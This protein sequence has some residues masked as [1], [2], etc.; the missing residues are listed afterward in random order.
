MPARPAP[1]STSCPAPAQRRT[2]AL[3]AVSSDGLPGARCPGARKGVAHLLR[4][5]DRR[6]LE[7]CLNPGTSGASCWLSWL[8]GPQAQKADPAPTLWPQPAAGPASGRQG[9]LLDGAAMEE[10]SR[11]QARS[12]KLGNEMPVSPGDATPRAA[13]AR[14]SHTQWWEDVECPGDSSAPRAAPLPHLLG[15]LSRTFSLYQELCRACSRGQ[16]RPAPSSWNPSWDT[17]APN[18]HSDLCHWPRAG[19]GF[20]RK[21]LGPVV[22]GGGRRGLRRGKV[23]PERRGGGHPRAVGVGD[24][25]QVGSQGTWPGG[26]APTGGL[27]SMAHRWKPDSLKRCWR[28][29]SRRRN[30][31]GKKKQDKQSGVGSCR[32]TSPAEGVPRGAEVG[33]EPLGPAPAL[34]CPRGAWG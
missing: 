29:A 7:S 25:L 31:R 3:P 26:L 33:S 9:R 17:D 8:W 18:P 23:R 1:T 4:R 32:R 19:S 5:G 20:P 28:Q 2:C 12:W 16:S 13:A 11:S 10:P 30:N 24:K 15:V 14:P 34:C 6:R 22:S 27:S 21:A